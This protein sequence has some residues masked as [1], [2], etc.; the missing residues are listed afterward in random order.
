MIVMLLLGEKLDKLIEENI[1][2]DVYTN[3]LQNLTDI[4]FKSDY[5]SYY[6]EPTGNIKLILIY[7]I[8][9][10]LILWCQH[11]LYYYFYGFLYRKNG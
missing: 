11:K 1:P 7:S 2:D 6:S 9:G 10:I 5:L 4:Y 8:I 3:T